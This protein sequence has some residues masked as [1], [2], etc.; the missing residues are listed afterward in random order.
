MNN[1][2][3]TLMYVITIYL[4]IL[5]IL[6]LFLPRTAETV[7]GISLPDA[8]LTMLYGQIVLTMAFL[9]YRIASEIGSY[10]K[11]S[12]VFIVLFGGHF[13]VWAYQLAT[14]I[15]TFAQVGPPFIISII[16]TVLLFFFGRN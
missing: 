9:S 14:G 6:F 1:R 4:L 13:L 10:A 7:F 3:R 15:S 2:L 11:L 5:G 8:A 12:T 16:F